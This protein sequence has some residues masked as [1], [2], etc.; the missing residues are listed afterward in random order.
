MLKKFAIVI[1]AAAIAIL[2]GAWLTDA[3]LANFDRIGSVTIGIWTAHPLEGTPN[4]DPYAKARLARD[5][6]IAMG[7]AE[8]VTFYAEIDD[9][10]ETLVST[11]DYLMKGS[12][13]A[14][15]FWT[16]LPLDTRKRGLAATR[17]GLPVSLTSDDLT[18]GAMQQ[19]EI[20]ISAYAR[21]GNWLAIPNGD[22]FLLALN[23]YDSPIATNKGLVDTSLPSIKRVRCHG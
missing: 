3:T 20:E 21:P 9:D 10:G 1:V 23:L 18:Y 11:C 6:N 4:S 7:A 12:N 22:R 17:D 15:R 8:G 13:L 14:A 16:L 2:G 5:A 19:F